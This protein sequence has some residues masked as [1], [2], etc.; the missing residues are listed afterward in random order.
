MTE[1]VIPHVNVEENEK[2]SDETEAE[3]KKDVAECI[4]LSKN[5]IKEELKTDTAECIKMTEKV[6]PHVIF[7]ENKKSSDEIEAELK[8]DVAECIEISKNE[9]KEEL[10]TD[11][12]E[13]IEMT[14]KVLP[15]V[16][17]EENKKSSDE[18][19]AEL[20]KDVA[21][22]IEISKNEIKEE[23]KTDIAECIEM[24]EKVISDPYDEITSDR[25]L[26]ARSSSQIDH[27]SSHTETRRTSRN[28]LRARKGFSG[29][30]CNDCGV[31][32]YNDIT[33][34]QKSWGHLIKQQSFMRAM[35]TCSICQRSYISKS[36]LL[37]HK[38]SSHAVALPCSIC[39]KV[40]QR[41]TLHDDHL[42]V[43][44]CLDRVHEK[45]EKVGE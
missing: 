23:L 9:I 5:E 32:C 29:I 18:I 33:E 3:L 22:C 35:H 10:K 40:F 20:K 12:A 43:H 26:E 15:H 13:C 37:K 27:G 24:I 36:G 39:G 44:R 19:E 34:H 8:K 11:T 1:K 42:M 45:A 21:E 2:S 41:K 17:F 4:E 38:A 6:L 28:N 25:D 7:E 31:H 30:F 16:I 14:E